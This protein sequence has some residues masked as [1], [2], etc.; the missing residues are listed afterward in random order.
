M[1][2]IAS[3]SLFLLNFLIL[4]VAGAACP[5]LE[6]KY[7]CVGNSKEFDGD[8]EISQIVLA[9]GV[10]QYQLPETGDGPGYSVN[11][12]TA[13]GKTRSRKKHSHFG[14]L[15]ANYRTECLSNTELFD[16]MEIPGWPQGGLS[17][18][19]KYTISSNGKVLE[20]EET[21]ILSNQSAKSGA[22]CTLQ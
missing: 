13:D 9:N 1:T 16:L 18:N 11:K 20:V 17:L 12:K 22:I 4:A 7:N 21:R 8:I 14:D 6:G 2:K 10:A 5:Q 19:T 3:I 15:V